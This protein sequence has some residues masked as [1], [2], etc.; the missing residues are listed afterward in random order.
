MYVEQIP[1]DIMARSKL[2]AGLLMFRRV[3]DQFQFLLVHPGGPYFKNKEDGAWTIPKGEVDPE[4]TD[5]LGTAKREFLEETGICTFGS[6]MALTHVKQKGGKT[7]HVWAFEGDCDP[8]SIVSN[9]FTM[10]WPPKSGKME[11]FPEIDRAAFFDLNTAR[12]RI[13]PGQI[14]LLIE[15]QDLLQHK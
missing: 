3:A 1:G 11:E 13:N 2:S 5:L 6:F 9:T 15:L 7:I 4:E 8:G 14:P 10:E 12:Q